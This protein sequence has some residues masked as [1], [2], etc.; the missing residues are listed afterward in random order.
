MAPIDYNDY[1]N[2]YNNNNNIIAA[3]LPFLLFYLINF[4][5]DKSGRLEI[6][7]SAIFHVFRFESST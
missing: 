1:N 2:D 3:I 7:K 5:G 4:G 6:S